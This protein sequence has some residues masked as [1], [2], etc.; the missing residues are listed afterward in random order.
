MEDGT[1]WRHNQAG[2]LAGSGDW[3]DGRKLKQLTAANKGKKG[4]TYTHK[5]KIKQ[6]HAKIKEANDNGFTV[7]L[8]AD[9]LDHADELKA[10][11]IGPVVVIVPADEA[12][13]HTITTQAG[14]KVNICPATYQDGMT[15]KK[16]QLCQHAGRSNMV[17]FPAHG[18]GK[19]NI[20]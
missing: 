7:N 13:N 2:D 14:N 18:S 11:G 5:H 4:F 20:T 1:L 8:S 19:G 15:C 17:G 3:V 16:C 12:Y 6:N 10:L 9:S